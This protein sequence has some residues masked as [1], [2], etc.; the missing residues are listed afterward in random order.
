ML[1]SVCGA[2]N[3]LS[4]HNPWSLFQDEKDGLANHSA[5]Q[6]KCLAENAHL[7]LPAAGKTTSKEANQS[8]VWKLE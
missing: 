2:L 4:C 5:R 6:T 7:N 1:V 8:A 3:E